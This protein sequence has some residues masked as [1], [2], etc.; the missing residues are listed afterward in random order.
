[1]GRIIIIASI[2]IATLAALAP[3]VAEAAPSVC[4]VVASRAIPSAQSYF[5]SLP[6]RFDSAAAS[7]TDAVVQWDLDGPCGG[8]WYAVIERGNLTVKR[9]TAPA[10]TLTI[11]MSADDYVAMVNQE[12][13]GRWLF[14]SGK[15]KVDG[16]IPLA[17]KLD[18]IFPLDG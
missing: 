15:G 7:R 10:P 6:D 11:S 17:M 1:M 8:A 4:A 14:V 2:V 3:R 5:D 9:G 16:S 18:S 12:V 13:N